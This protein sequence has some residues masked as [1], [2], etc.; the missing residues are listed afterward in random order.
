[1]ANLRNCSQCGRIFP[2]QGRNI[3]PKC[4]EKEEDDF[5]L[6]RRFVRDH[7]GAS[8]IEVSEETG[9]EED[10]ILQFLRDGRL[11]SKGLAKV[12]SC[13]RCGKPLSTGRL[14]EQCTKE[15][16]AEIQGI[17]PVKAA[18]SEPEKPSPRKGRDR[19]HVKGRED[20]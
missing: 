2:Y 10:K 20:F 9:I 5:Q 17:A 18:K 6:V 19:M 13:E 8:V 16:A 3:C 7:P 1:M 4:L 14:C 15:V 12:L 11:Q